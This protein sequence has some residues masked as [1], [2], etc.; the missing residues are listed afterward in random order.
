MACTVSSTYFDLLLGCPPLVDS[1]QDP[2][3]DLLNQQVEVVTPYDTYRGIL[4]SVE[5]DYIVVSD[6]GTL[7]LIRIAKI[8]TVKEI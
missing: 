5:S 8:D 3:V 1:D 2:L 4:I 6:S 7:T